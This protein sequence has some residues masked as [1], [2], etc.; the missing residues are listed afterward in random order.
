MGDRVMSVIQAMGGTGGSYRILYRHS[1]C[2][3][4]SHICLLHPSSKR[5]LPASCSDTHTTM[6]NDRQSR[7]HMMRN[8]P[9]PQ[10]PAV[11]GILDR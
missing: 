9:K 10:A 7:Q 8:P 6:T 2:L 5:V 1:G 3:H 4:M 11:V